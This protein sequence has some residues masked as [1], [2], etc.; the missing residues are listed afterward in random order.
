MLLFLITVIFGTANFAGNIY[1]TNSPTGYNST[2]STPLGQNGT[3]P[4]TY[5]FDSA[6]FPQK[7]NGSTWSSFVSPDPKFF[8][9]KALMS[10]I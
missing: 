10:D 6:V 5:G 1:G 2:F 9:S 4:D 7:K 8:N 3:F